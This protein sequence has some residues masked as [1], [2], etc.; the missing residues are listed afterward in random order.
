MLMV[1]GADPVRMRSGYP[2]GLSRSVAVTFL[3][4]VTDRLSDRIA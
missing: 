3:I 4:A 1:N 2:E